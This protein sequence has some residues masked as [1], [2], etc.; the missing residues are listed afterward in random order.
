MGGEGSES[1]VTSS[2]NMKWSVASES[3][4]PHSSIQ[5]ICSKFVFNVY[6]LVC[7]VLWCFGFMGSMYIFKVV[8]CYLFQVM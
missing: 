7:L 4:V 5:V 1:F 2:F 6:F 8:M 3:D